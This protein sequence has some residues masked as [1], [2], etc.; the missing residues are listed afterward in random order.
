MRD[1]W[2]GIKEVMARHPATQKGKAGYCSDCARFGRR[3]TDLELG[4]FWG[5]S[6]LEPLSLTKA[7]YVKTTEPEYLR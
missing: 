3:N 4:Y 1:V 7:S 5:K 2:E 6:T